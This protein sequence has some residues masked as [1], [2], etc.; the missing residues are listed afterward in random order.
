MC[1]RWEKRYNESMES[2]K[3]LLKITERAVQTAEKIVEREEKK[4][5]F[6]IK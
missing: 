4:K 1:D 2:N 3:R 5:K 6:E